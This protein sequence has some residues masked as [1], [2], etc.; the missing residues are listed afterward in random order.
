MLSQR[1]WRIRTV[2]RFALGMGVVSVVGF[3]TQTRNLDPGSSRII[4]TMVVGF[5]V[6]MFLSGDKSYADYAKKHATKPSEPG[7]KD[8]VGRG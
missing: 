5:A 7:N 2:I 3:W 4:N 1:G 6:A 8:A